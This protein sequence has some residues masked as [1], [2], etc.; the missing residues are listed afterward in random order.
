MKRAARNEEVEARMR[1]GATTREGFLGTD[2]R[3]LEEILDADERA[4]KGLGRT[5]AAI[6][7]RMRFFL[8]AGAAGFGETVFVAPHFEI[9]VESARGFLECPFGDP[10]IV[11]KTNVYV[12]NGRLNK[13]VIYSD[14]S[15]HLIEAHGFYQGHGGFYRYE[16]AWLVE[17][18]EVP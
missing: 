16:P 4:V 3:R 1:A 7:A 11:L 15:I 8:E 5:H 10:G 2:R 13:D 17:V 14:L 9:R 18:L 12:T 6:A